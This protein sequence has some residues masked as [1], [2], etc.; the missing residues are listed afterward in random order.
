[1]LE[2]TY[3]VYLYHVFNVRESIPSFV[4][5]DEPFLDTA[6]LLAVLVLLLILPKGGG[7]LRIW[8]NLDR[9]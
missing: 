9:K 3:Q 1:M 8:E 4:E 5:L 6:K 2:R 7:I